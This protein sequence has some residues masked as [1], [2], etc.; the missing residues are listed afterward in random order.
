MDFADLVFVGRAK[1][2]WSRKQLAERVGVNHTT[3]LRIEE[4]QVFGFGETIVRI[5][6]ELELDPCESV[7]AL[8]TS[9]AQRGDGERRAEDAGDSGAD[10]ST[11]AHGALPV[12]PVPT[13]QLVMGSAPAA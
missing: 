7:A 1:K 6:Q 5:I 11:L 13:R 2:R 12:D 8:K 4:R 10:W 9:L 3:I